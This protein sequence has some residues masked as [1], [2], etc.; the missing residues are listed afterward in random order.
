MKKEEAADYLPPLLYK[1]GGHFLYEMRMF[2]KRVNPVCGYLQLT[3][4]FQF[5][6][7]ILEIAF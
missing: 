1:K 4:I 7:A 2:V 6:N 3:V 5:T